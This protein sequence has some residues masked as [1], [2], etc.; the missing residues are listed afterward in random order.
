[1]QLKIVGFL[2]LLASWSGL[3]LAQAPD[4]TRRD[5][6]EIDLLLSYYSQDGDNAAVTGGIGTQELKD[7][8]SKILIHIPI[9]STSDL[10]I[11]SGIS[12]YTS[13]STDRID[14]RM[15][16]ASAADNRGQ[17][18][19]TYNRKPKPKSRSV[20]G[21]SAGA[22]LE[23]DYFSSGLGLSWSTITKSG[24]RSWT[25]S[26]QLLLDRWIMIFPD[27]VRDRAHLVLTTDKRRAFNLSVNM[28]QVINKRLQVS[29]NADPGVQWGLLST[30]FHRVY[31]H[32]D[33]VGIE[34]LPE[35][36]FRF[37][38]GVRANYFL[39]DYVVLRGGY[40]YF[41]DDQGLSAHTIS[42]E[43]PVKFGTV[44]S[45]YPAY[46]FYT[47]TANNFFL[48]FGLHDPAVRFHT[49][50]FDLSAFHSHRYSVGVRFSPL[51]VLGIPRL[52]ADARLQFRQMSAQVAWYLR[53][54]GLRA[55]IVSSNFSF[56]F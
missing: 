45:I 24:N 56:S 48:P 47:Q 15:S 38:V 22:S 12:H 19:F 25:I 32:N 4:S 30:P 44:L 23:S 3:L 37:P 18:Y 9:D 31:F 39:N 7:Y 8:S 1:M 29:I 13:A 2:L 51:G 10:D 40:R 34:V 52:P 33:S 41:I 16:S 27:E 6:V 28:A 17:M 50:D 43:V 35:R 36:R 26:S 49:S 54:D 14:F 5:P 11:T 55:F 46:R 42:M 53:S 21:I 20:W